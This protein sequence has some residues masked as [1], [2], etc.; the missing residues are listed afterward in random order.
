MSLLLGCNNLKNIVLLL[1]TYFHETLFRETYGALKCRHTGRKAG[2]VRSFVLLFLLFTGWVQSHA[3][4]ARKTSKM[5]HACFGWHLS[6]RTVTSFGFGKVFSGWHRLGMRCF[7]FSSRRK[8]A[9]VLSELRSSVINIC[10]SSRESSKK[11]SATDSLSWGRNSP[12][13]MSL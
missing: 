9:W 12:R 3:G 5:I 6:P 7:L 11:S 2:S 1:N 13:L 4:L 10:V 8:L